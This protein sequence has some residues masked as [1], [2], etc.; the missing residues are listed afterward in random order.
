MH[1]DE[2]MFA[3]QRMPPLIGDWRIEI[4]KLDVSG[5]G[6][7][8]STEDGACVVFRW[9]DMHPAPNATWII[10]GDDATDVCTALYHDERGEARC[11]SGFHATRV[12]NVPKPTK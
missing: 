6:A 5:H 4:P 10:G 7:G 3:A 9:R 12:A 1:D 2:T 8:E 11:R